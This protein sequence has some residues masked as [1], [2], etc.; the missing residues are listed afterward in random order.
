MKTQKNKS[1]AVASRNAF[2]K[3]GKFL[4]KHS[5][6]IAVC[7]LLTVMAGNI[8]FAGGPNAET[9][10]NTLKDT[11]VKWVGRLG[12]VTML[13]GGIMFGLGWRNDDPT[14]KTNG[15][16]TVIAG[17]IVVAVTAIANQFFV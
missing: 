4:D 2:A 10:W 1:L 17:A 8:V 7:L 6:V 11:I 13:I 12:G 14:Q 15:I 16:S 3:V 9:L 5:N